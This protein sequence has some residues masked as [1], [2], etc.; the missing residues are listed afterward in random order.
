MVR[1]CNGWIEGKNRREREG[2]EGGKRNGT[3]INRGRI[4][5]YSM[6]RLC[7]ATNEH[8]Q[9]SNTHTQYS[10]LLVHMCISINQYMNHINM[11]FL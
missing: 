1:H 6:W 7:I 10:G 2:R 4:H 9:F 8:G 3:R 5:R 11:T